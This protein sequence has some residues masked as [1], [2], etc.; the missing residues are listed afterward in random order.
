R[1]CRNKNIGKDIICRLHKDRMDYFPVVTKGHAIDDFI[2]AIISIR[3]HT[4]DSIGCIIIQSVKTFY[5]SYSS[6]FNVLRDRSD[7]FGED[8]FL[9]CVHKM[10]PVSLNNSR[11]QE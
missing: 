9:Y 6:E 2:S 1:F 5:N 10:L 11:Q 3:C 7:K 4:A 8:R